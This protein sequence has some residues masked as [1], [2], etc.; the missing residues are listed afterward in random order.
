MSKLVSPKARC[1]VLGCRHSVPYYGG[2]PGMPQAHCPHCG[3]KNSCAATGCPDF[4]EPLYP[5]ADWH[6]KLIEWVLKLFRKKNDQG[7]KS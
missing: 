1:R 3:M 4:T 2:Y 7:V 5:E 6:W